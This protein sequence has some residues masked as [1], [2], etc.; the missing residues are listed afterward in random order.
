M[1]VNV[2]FSLS[3]FIAGS[4]AIYVSSS[5]KMAKHIF[6]KPKL[7]GCQ[8]GFWFSNL[9][10]LQAARKLLVHNEGVTAAWNSGG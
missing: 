5:P 2:V 3:F 6:P 1:G 8:H 7:D 9:P 10:F 4:P